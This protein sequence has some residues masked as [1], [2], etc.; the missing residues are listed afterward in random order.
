MQTL[1]DASFLVEFIYILCVLDNKMKQVEFYS[2]KM[3]KPFHV[4][5]NLFQPV[6]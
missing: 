4:S 3:V 1:V 2:L 5:Q 6:T